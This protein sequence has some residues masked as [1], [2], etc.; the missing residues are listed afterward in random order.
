MAA[1]LKKAEE[2][3]LPVQLILV[4]PSDTGGVGAEGLA[5]MARL[6]NRAETHNATVVHLEQA[7]GSRAL[8]EHIQAM[9][10]SGEEARFIFVGEHSSG[11]GGLFSQNSLAQKVTARFGGQSQVTVIPLEGQP[12]KARLWDQLE[13][14]ALTWRTLI[15]PLV[16][17]ASAYLIARAG[18]M[19]MPAIYY[20]L[21]THNIALIFLL[22]C[23]VVALR[24]GVAAAVLASLMSVAIINYAFIVPIRQF[25]IGTTAD[26]ISIA[27]FLV[28]A[29]VVSIL[30]GRVRLNVEKTRN[31]EQRTKALYDLQKMTAEAENRH[32]LME[33]LDRELRRVLGMEMAFFMHTPTGDAGRNSSINSNE[34]AFE[35]YPRKVDLSENDVR[36]LEKCWQTNL[37][38]GFGTLRGIRADWYFEPIATAERRYGVLGVSV[39]LKRRTDAGFARFVSAL[40]D[41]AAIAMDRLDVLDR[42]QES[43]IRE[44]RENLR[45]MLLSSVS[46]DLKT[47]LASI[48]GSISVLKSLKSK[49]RLT[50]EQ[51]VTLSDTAL[52]EAQRLDN[53]ITNIL[54]MTKLESGEIEFQ[55]RPTDPMEPLSQARKTLQTRLRDRTLNIHQECNGVEVMMD[56]MMTAQVLQNVI[57]NAAKYSPEQTE[58]DV[59]M[60]CNDE[61]FEYR[62]RDHGTGIPEEARERIFDKYERLSKTDSQVAGT[63]LGL[64][65]SRT[66]MTA[67]GGTIKARNH[68]DGGA[69]FVMRFPAAKSSK[70]GESHAEPDQ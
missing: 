30:G 6:E 54:S 58:I 47:P 61:G 2:S 20:K 37:S 57:D 16:A 32:Q 42:M 10:R 40:A 15:M 9:H 50:D 17:V 27:I 3:R 63:G 23:V 52:D 5:V 43:R 14:G 51:L 62:I 31:R 49:G 67:Q 38:S 39:P 56:G 60:A 13:L 70:T 18:Q 68:T 55:R 34:L 7:N 36:A 11:R 33:I 22:A 53:F 21:N 41:H 19:L 59:T 44:E 28:A 35:N 1:G 24:N 64:A 8:V 69:E 4:D 45:S 12:D 25:N 65:I 29:L 66:V 26:I 48:I 46:H